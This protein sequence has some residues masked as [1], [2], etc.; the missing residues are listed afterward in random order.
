MTLFIDKYVCWLLLVRTYGYILCHRN[1]IYTLPYIH[2][3][4]WCD[5]SVHREDYLDTLVHL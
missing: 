5:K 4:L 2:T 1:V 3:P